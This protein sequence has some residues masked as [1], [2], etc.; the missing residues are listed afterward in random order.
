MEREFILLKPDTV[1]RGLV[2]EVIKRIENTGLKLIAMKFLQVTQDMAEKHYAVHKERPFYPN[3]VKYITSGPTVAM[4]V[5]GPN[6]VEK[7]RN[8]VGATHPKDAT[9]GTIRGDFGIDIGR[10]LIHASD[11]V[12]NSTY[13]TGIYFTE[14]E[15]VSW[16]PI[17]QPWVVE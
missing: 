17:R 2:G 8:V 4:V 6:A 12:E 9:P 1:Q 3:L 14:E 16:T 11:S 15:M 7:T 13:E 10:N 5:E